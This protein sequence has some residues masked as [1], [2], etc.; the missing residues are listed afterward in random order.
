MFCRTKVLD[1]LCSSPSPDR[2]CDPIKHLPILCLSYV[3][4]HCGKYSG[5]YCAA[6]AEKCSGVRITSDNAPK[7]CGSI[8][9]ACHVCM[10]S[11]MNQ[12]FPGVSI[13]QVLSR[14]PVH[15]GMG[16][17]VLSTRQ[18]SL[19]QLL[20]TRDSCQEIHR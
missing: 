19:F 15:R 10:V 11:R 16:L 13:V 5:P 20:S 9:S 8:P 3:P 17:Q 14:Y 12:L 18:K 6:P 1:H 7:S 4:D 2:S